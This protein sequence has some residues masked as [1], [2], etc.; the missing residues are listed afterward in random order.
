[1]ISTRRDVRIRRALPEEAEALT[2]L[3]RRAKSYWGYDQSFLEA[4]RPILTLK[5][6][7]IEHDP[8]Y[9]AEIGNM[10]IGVSHLKRMD[11]VTVCLDDL[12]VE[13]ALIGQG[14]G[15]L[16]WRH[17]VEMAKTMGATSLVFDADPH[18]RP[19]YEHMGAVVEGYNLSTI[20]PGRK[21]PRMRYE[22]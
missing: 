15:G 2:A 22:W 10:V 20:V 7:S 1:M 9:C 17:A 13:P 8:V 11:E 4:C 5:P 21:T 16:L 3:I 6:E 18:A 14:I 12:F 19:F